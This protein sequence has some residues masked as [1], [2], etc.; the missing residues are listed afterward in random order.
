MATMLKQLEQLAKMNN[1]T[2][3]EML[4]AFKPC[5][6]S[7]TTATTVVTET[8]RATE[9]VPDVVPKS[10]TLLDGSKGPSGMQLVICMTTGRILGP[11]PCPQSFKTAVESMVK[12]LENSQV[13]RR[14]K[15]NPG[16]G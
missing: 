12:E 15:F 3:E 1:T 5:R 8:T 6:P 10:C 7:M 4:A 9:P 16:K 14:R 11:T 2:V 13:G